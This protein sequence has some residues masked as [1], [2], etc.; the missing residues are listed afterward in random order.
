MK[1]SVACLGFVLA[2][3]SAAC[4]PSAGGAG[5]DDDDGT[6]DGDGPDASPWEPRPDATPCTPSQATETSCDDNTD[7]DCDGWYDCDDTDCSGVG[8]CPVCGEATDVEGQP[9]ALPDVNSGTCSADYT[10]TIN[11]V[12]FGATQTLPDVSKFLGVCVTMEHSWLRDVQIEL[13]A[14]NGANIVLQQFRGTTGGSVY[15]GVPVHEADETGAPTPGTGWEYC[16]TPSAIN[17]P[18]L[19]WANANPLSGTLPAGDYQAEPPA[20][21]P[22]VGGLLNGPWTIRVVDCW[23]LD[24]GFIFDW[25]VKFDPSLV[26]DCSVPI[27]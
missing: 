12:G 10:S 5:D 17:P 20:F 3:L 22:L 4:G 18:T 27:D 19:D 21:G 9:V 8:D 23:G 24:N 1:R 13:R 25:T 26:T 7:N 15:M 16:W 2:C 14:P 11:I 6:G